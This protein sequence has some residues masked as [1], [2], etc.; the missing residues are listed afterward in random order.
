[1][2]IK[3][4]AGIARMHELARRTGGI[5]SDQDVML[6][7]PRAKMAATVPTPAPKKDWT[8]TEL[9]EK[10]A[11]WRMNTVR[12][13][14]AN[15]PSIARAHGKGAPERLVGA[16]VAAKYRYAEYEGI[17]TEEEV[18]TRIHDAVR[19]WNKAHHDD[20]VSFIEKGGYKARRMELDKM[21]KEDEDTLMSIEGSDETVSVEG[22]ELGADPGVRKGK[23]TASR[24]DGSSVEEAVQYGNSFAGSW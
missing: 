11:T 8:P 18:I 15:M 5:V 21:A 9:I 19:E 4:G 6:G 13:I 10:S 23:G 24:D 20:F 3:I 16:L 12:W 1:M 14:D 22:N 7:S 2:S 17:A